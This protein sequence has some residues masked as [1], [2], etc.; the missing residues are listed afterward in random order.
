MK[1]KFSLMELI[2]SIKT[3]LLFFTLYQN[4]LTKFILLPLKGKQN[5][6][7]NMLQLLYFMLFTPSEILLLWIYDPQLIDLFFFFTNQK[8][9]IL[10]L[11]SDILNSSKILPFFLTKIFNLLF[12]PLNNNFL[13]LFRNL[14]SINFS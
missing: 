3:V 7:L 6:V 10:D 8:F 12:Q 5:M 2:A 9:D 14:P 13:A 4:V 11:V 1:L